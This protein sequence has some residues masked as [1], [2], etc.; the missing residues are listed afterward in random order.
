[1]TTE[2]QPPN[3]LINQSVV[4][5]SSGSLTGHAYSNTVDTP[6]VGPV[7][8]ILKKADMPEASLG[9]VIT[10]RL[11]VANTGN[12]DARVTLLDNMPEG[13]SFVPNSVIVA[14]VP[15]PLANPAQGI[16]LGTVHIGQTITVIFQIVV[17]KPPHANMIRNQA[18][19][20]YTFRTPSGR[21]VSG[22][23]RSNTVSIPFKKM[24]IKFSK[25][26]DPLDTYVGDSAT[27]RFTI[28]NE[29]DTAI[30]R[31]L[32]QD[33]LA[34]GMTFI[35]GSVI[36]DD[37]R[38][39]SANP[40]EGIWLGTLP[41][42]ASFNLQF[43]AAV[44][45]FP[46]SGFLE[47]EGVLSYEE[48][49][50]RNQTTSNT[51]ELRVFDPNLR[52]VE[53]VR[54]AAATLGDALTYTVT[55]TN[56]GNIATEVSLTEFLPEG[57]SYVASSL[58]V[59]G[60]PY[61]QPQLPNPLPLG[62]LTPRTSIVVTFQVSVNTIAISASHKELV[63]HAVALFSYRLPD[64]RGIA[65]RLISN[66]VHVALLQPIVDVQMYVHPLAA[67]PG[68]VLEYVI[69][70]TNTGSLTAGAL[71]MWNWMSTMNTLVPGSLHIRHHTLPEK[72]SIHAADR[73]NI[74]PE[75]PLVIGDLDPETSVEI[76]YEAEISPHLHAPR[77]ATQAE[78]QYSY[79]V[80]EPV[81]AGSVL[82]NPISV[83][84]EHADE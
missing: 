36:L 56:T 43:Q 54:E 42:H 6:V 48:G 9:Q 14:G 3:H 10:Y 28:A 59:N 46:P 79:Q 69:A 18:V 77:I 84:I 24:K 37:I 39:P 38:Y 73:R 19:A 40:M 61:R 70:V 21:E 68:A 78:A 60:Q 57:T 51:V 31:L 81:H 49:D 66:E 23:S 16:P 50:Y 33:A 75:Q 41:D 67:E 13:T 7:I 55:L 62:A 82:S 80:N 20:P 53:S 27:F 15:L 2:S 1:M 22:Q 76:T 72:L 32:F 65:N 63:S 34:P 83:R 64:G 74:V 30:P 52:V 47:N 12:L 71:Q 26:A 17:L 29:E 58:T 45:L 4:R 44:S 35:P 25:L 8:T 5:F 11:I